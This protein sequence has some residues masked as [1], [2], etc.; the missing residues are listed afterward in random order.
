MTKRSVVPIVLA[1]V[2]TGCAADS[3]DDGA[4]AEAQD[5]TARRDTPAPG[6][7]VFAASNGWTIARDD[8]K[9]F[10]RYKLLDGAIYCETRTE[11]AGSIADAVALLQ[12]KWD[13][14]GG[15]VRDFEVHADGHRTYTLFP[16]GRLAVVNVL[17]DMSPPERLVD[18]G[19]RVLIHLE[20]FGS[21]QAYIEL[22]PTRGDRFQMIGRFAGVRSNVLPTKTFAEAHLEAEA[23]RFLGFDKE[24]G[25][26][27]FRAALAR[28]HG[29]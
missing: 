26:E 15:W 16:Q 29:R 21:G 1:L 27:G 3:A 9:Y 17:E 20:G 25:F 18:G 24:G 4:E 11:L 14:Y 12:A 28:S 2:L 6:H 10:Q 7:E 13:W 22:H 5:V 23:G 19:V 8:A